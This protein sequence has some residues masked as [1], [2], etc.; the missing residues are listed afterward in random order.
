MDFNNF[1]IETVAKEIHQT[2]KDKG[3]WEASANLNVK[4]ALIITEL[5]EAVDAHREEKYAD[6]EQ[7]KKEYLH[8]CSASSR[9]R[10]EDRKILRASTEADLVL[11][12]D[13]FQRYVKDSVEDELADTYIRCLDLLVKEYEVWHVKLEELPGKLND[14]IEQIVFTDLFPENVYSL[15][16]GAFR[17]RGDT[18]DWTEGVCWGIDQIAEIEGID[19]QKHIE[20][21]M[22]FNKTREKL[23]GNKTY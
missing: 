14:K 20:M 18:G 12:A 10:Y 5:A 21:K 6:V 13:L 11:Y 3:F 2:A 7:L 9:D 15:L 16:R 8:E 23:H 19:L 1:D 4:R 22:T 17:V